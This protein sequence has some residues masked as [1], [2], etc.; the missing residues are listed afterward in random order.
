MRSPIHVTPRAPQFG[1]ATPGESTPVLLPVS[2]YARGG[3]FVD[4]STMDGWVDPGDK[5]LDPPVRRRPPNAG[6]Q[7]QATR[8][9]APL[10]ELRHRDRMHAD[11]RSLAR[12]QD[13]C[14]STPAISMYRFHLALSLATNAAM[15]VRAIGL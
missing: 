8:A 12:R 5:L 10:H 4:R 9:Y 1:R 11:A 14:L 2:I 6:W 13:Y 7:S 3:V 15:L